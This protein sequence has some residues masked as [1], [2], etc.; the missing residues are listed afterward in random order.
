MKTLYRT[1]S[2]N[3]K[4]T[5]RIPENVPEHVIQQKINYIYDVLKPKSKKKNLQQ[6]T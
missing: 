6:T 3:V 1:T 5:I 4:V 2:D